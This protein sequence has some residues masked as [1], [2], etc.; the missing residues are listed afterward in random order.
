[1]SRF[2]P[3]LG[4]RSLAGVRR[5]QLR[6]AQLRRLS[7]PVLCAELPAGGAF[8]F[9]LASC[10]ATT[11]VLPWASVAGMMLAWYAAEALLAHAFDRPLRARIAHD[12]LWPVLWVQ[13]WVAKGYDW[14]GNH[15]DLRP[16]R[17]APLVLPTTRCRLLRRNWES[18]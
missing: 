12:L 8:A 16:A 15:I 11:E 1:M 5:R 13:A 17:G 4:R 10:L 6:W 2:F 18:E 7:F 9:L 3:P 14:R